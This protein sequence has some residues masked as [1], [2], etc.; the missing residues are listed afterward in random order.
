MAGSGE[1][2]EEDEDE[3]SELEIAM[4]E[5]REKGY[6]YVLRG[7]FQG[8]ERQTARLVM[9][10]IEAERRNGYAWYGN[11]G[12]KVLA[13]W[14]EWEEGRGREAGSPGD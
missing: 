7:T 14:R 3:A 10:E 6:A 12:A 1:E 4:Q 13:R 9:K 11:W 8:V 2:D 5:M